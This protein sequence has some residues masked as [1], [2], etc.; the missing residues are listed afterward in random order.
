MQSNTFGRATDQVRR[1]IVLIHFSPF[2]RLYFTSY[3][4]CW[5]INNSHF[6]Q[7]EVHQ[8]SPAHAQCWR[9][10]ANS[11]KT[12]LASSKAE[13]CN[14][15]QYQ[16]LT[17]RTKGEKQESFLRFPSLEQSSSDLKLTLETASVLSYLLF[18]CLCFNATEISFLSL[19]LLLI[20]CTN[21]PFVLFIVF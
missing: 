5:L 15:T 7:Q 11:G 21:F 17:E 8:W 4:L 13:D 10:Q 9:T 19:C 12:G 20:K 2:R 3:W 18:I 14:H 16:W 1:L 6:F